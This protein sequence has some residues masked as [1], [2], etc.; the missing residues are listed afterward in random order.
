MENLE[1]K[2]FLSIDEANVDIRRFTIFIGPQA[3]G[4]SVIAK[5]IYFFR[6]SLATHYARSIERLETKLQLEKTVIKAFEEIFPRYAWID[7]NFE[8]IYKTEDIELKLYRKDLSY[9]KGGIKFEISENLGDLQKK[10]KKFYQNKLKEE[11]PRRKDSLYFPR[12]AYYITLYECIFSS[13]LGHNFQSSIFIPAGRSF[14]A[15]L[16]NNV[17]SFLANNI[18]IDP[19]IK[20]FGSIYESG[21]AAYNRRFTVNDDK[22]ISGLREDIK[23]EFEKILTGKYVYEDDQDW[24]I[25]GKRRTNLANASS[26]QQEVLPL[27][28]VLSNRLIGA[29]KDQRPVTFFIEEPEA[30]LFPVSQRRLIGIFSR[31]Y[32]AFNYSF[33]LTTHSPYILTAFNNLILASNI[34]EEKGNDYTAKIKK[35]LNNDQPIKFDDVRAYTIKDGVL[36]SILNHENKLIGSSV[37]DSVSDE[38]D[39]VFDQLLDISFDYDK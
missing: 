38:F 18:S 3:N 28:L 9:K 32:N 25:T 31:F 21:K 11:E 35:I 6:Q 22:E 8:L 17:F 12:D 7:Q 39:K 4:K 36:T 2:N 1:I 16:Q 34:I 13:S 30:H 24:I 15:N 10:A 20:Q 33:I 37:I 5:I 27:I 29:A 23:Q 19:L 14:F 26:G